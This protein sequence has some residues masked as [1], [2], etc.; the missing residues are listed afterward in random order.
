M[1]E[2]I[3]PSDYLH[4][5]DR[6][7]DTFRYCSNCSCTTEQKLDVIYDLYECQDCWNMLGIDGEIVL[8][9]E[10]EYYN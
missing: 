3:D 1:P 10:N 4:Y 6:E 8:I 5:I 9:E 7:E 2:A